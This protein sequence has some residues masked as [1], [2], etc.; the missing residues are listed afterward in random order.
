MK[1]SKVKITLILGI[2]V[3]LLTSSIPSG[4]F[5]KTS[6]VSQL[7]ILQQDSGTAELLEQTP[8]VTF[9]TI[10]KYSMETQ[11]LTLTHSEIQTLSDIYQGIMEEMATNPTSQNTLRL[12]E[13]FADL[14]LTNSELS[15]I[16]TKH[17]LLTYFR[18]PLQRM[19]PSHPTPTPFQSKATEWFCNFITTGTGSAFPIIILP[20]LIPILLI[21][22][23]RAFVGWSTSEGITSVG[24]LISRTGFI[25]DGEQQGI[26][27]GFWGIGFSIFLPPIMSYGLFGYA[28]YAK[29]TAEEIEYW[30][31]NN[32]PEIT[33]TD[34]A[35]GE[36]MVPMTTS[37]LRFAIHD[38]DG[39][40]MSYNVTTEPNIGSGS[41]GLK[42]DGIYSI[43][44]S[45]L[46]SSTTYTW[47]IELT[48]GKDSIKKTLTF[49][50]ELIA[51]IVSNPSPK[52]HAQFVPTEISELSF[53]LM[54]HQGDL[55][56]WTVETKPSIGSGSGSNVNNGRYSISISD[57]D[58][59]TNYTWFINVTDSAHWTRKT[60]VFRTTAENTR[61]F[62]PTDDAYVSSTA[63]DQNTGNQVSLSIRSGGSNN[64]W[65]AAPTIKFDLSSLPTN[66][67]ILSATLN[68]YYYDYADG[69]PAGRPLVMYRFLSDWIESTITW[70]NMPSIYPVQ[71]TTSYV[72]STPGTWISWDVTNDVQEF[73]EGTTSNYGWIIKD[74]ASS[75][76]PITYIRPK[77]YGSYIPYLILEL[78][79][80]K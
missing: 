25:A 50:T 52:D 75:G 44:I 76:L 28:L 32:S 7:E 14:L 69:N 1:E 18:V 39:E 71:T 59:F 24:G 68:I 35:D 67:S 33:Q 41:G 47:H 27:L 51:P 36:Q 78:T 48:D 58:F 80:P 70:D 73:I 40:T 65:W 22:I 19:T 60:Y 64:H 37:V 46:E 54:D 20:R 55:M 11:R 42:P 5:G 38:A 66:A 74:E 79:T 43:P 13:Q 53:D 57:L 29:V 10:G 26:A 2:I 77:E 30:P 6:T 16:Y 12:Q 62:E 45:G 9:Y 3:L 21:P 63:P 15:E 61:V 23:P 17:Q 49:T 34:P 4:S 56:D 8:S 31:P 72:P